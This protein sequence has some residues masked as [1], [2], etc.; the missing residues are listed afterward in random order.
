M[1]RSAG[2]RDGF[3]CTIHLCESNRKGAIERPPFCRRTSDSNP[4]SSHEWVVIRESRRSRRASALRSEFG[5]LAESAAEVVA[6][7][8]TR[9]PDAFAKSSRQGIAYTHGGRALA[10]AS[11][12][13][14]SRACRRQCSRR[15][16]RGG[17]PG[18]HHSG[19][20]KVLVRNEGWRGLSLPRLKS[21]DSILGQVLK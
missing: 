15:P 7:G 13:A 17:G 14:C 6:L 3:R 9:F 10:K 1:D 2:A 16:G 20:R 11:P 12:C 5:R 8:D 21:T 19:G 4:E 18:V